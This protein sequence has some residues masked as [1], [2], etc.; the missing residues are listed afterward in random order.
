MNRVKLFTA[1]FLAVLLTTTSASASCPSAVYGYNIGGYGSYYIFYVD[2]SCLSSS[3]VTPST[4]GGCG[5][6]AYEFGTG[7]SQYTE[8]S[9][10]VPA[11]GTTINNGTFNQISTNYSVKLFIDFNSPT[12]TFY[13]NIIGTVTVN[14]NGSNS[15]TTF[16]ALYGNSAATET[17]HEHDGNFTATN[18]DTITI[19]LAV[20]K[21]GSGSVIKTGIPIVYNLH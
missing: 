11:N 8:W 2:S 21:W 9:F 14:H 3:S 20:T 15:Y 6:S 10:V 16:L 13:D 17:C 5:D 1:V 4:L 12:Q 7:Y 18:G 19:R